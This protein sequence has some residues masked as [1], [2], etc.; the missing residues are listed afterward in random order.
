M[1]FFLY[2]PI[3]IWN[4]N[5]IKNTI[6]NLQQTKFWHLIFL[7][8]SLFE[9]ARENLVLIAYATSKGLVEPVVLPEP[10]LLVH[11]NMDVDEGSGQNLGL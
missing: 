3:P 8:Y 7:F 4:Y 9:P 6:N 1:K 10:L 5:N 11:T 2:K